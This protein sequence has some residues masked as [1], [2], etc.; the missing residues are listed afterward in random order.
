MG[1]SYRQQKRWLKR[2]CRAKGIL[3]RKGFST[4][5]EKWGKQAQAMWRDVCKLNRV[6][7]TK[8]PTG[9]NINLIRPFRVRLRKRIEMELGTKEWSP[10]SNWGEVRKYLSAA[11][12]RYPAPYCAS[13][14]TYCVKKAGWEHS[15]PSALA[16]VPSWD[17]WAKSKGYEVAKLKARKA[18]LA[19]FNWDSDAASEHIGFILHNY[20]LYKQVAT[21]EGNATSA[22]APGGGVVKKWR[23]WDQVNHVY[24][25]PNDW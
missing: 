5:R 9:A 14:V 7:V 19:S 21:I 17:A 1:N 15:L 11:G 6:T 20:G 12:I 13:F 22:A 18:D 4:L 10:S 8:Q 16:W 24:R 2:Y 3:R 25:L 23:R